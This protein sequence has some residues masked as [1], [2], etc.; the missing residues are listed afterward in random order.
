ML[1]DSSR[2][3]TKRLDDRN[4][5]RHIQIQNKFLQ[6]IMTSYFNSQ[7]NKRN[8]TSS[9]YLHHFCLVLACLLSNTDIRS[10]C[11]SLCHFN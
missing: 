9:N 6:V 7:S 8:D 4:M 11:P 1:L 5:L 2:V 10:F 3:D